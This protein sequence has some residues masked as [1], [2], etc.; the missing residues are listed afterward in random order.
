MAATNDCFNIQLTW[1][2]FAASIKQL[3]SPQKNSEN[4]DHN[5]PAISGF[6]PRDIQLKFSLLLSPNAVKVPKM[7]Q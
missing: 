7:S 5:S 1:R 2:L 6:R 4:A 3:S